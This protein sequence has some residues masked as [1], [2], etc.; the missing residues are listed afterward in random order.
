MIFLHINAAVEALGHNPLV[1]KS[2]VLLA[3]LLQLKQGYESAKSKITTDYMVI[4]SNSTSG[5]N[6]NV[7]K[8]IQF[9][10]DS[11]EL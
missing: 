1:Y 5:A 6:K 10:N 4:Q 3:G 9:K 7:I 8:K 11:N 2:I